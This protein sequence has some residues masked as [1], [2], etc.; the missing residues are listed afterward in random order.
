[1]SNSRTVSS[2][3]AAL[4]VAGLAGY[5]LW[6][7]LQPVDA[8][9]QPDLAERTRLRVEEGRSYGRASAPELAPLESSLVQADQQD[10][11]E[12]LRLNKAGLK[13][14]RASEYAASVEHFRAALR[15]EPGNEIIMLN[16]SRALSQWGQ[17]ELSEGRMQTALEHFEEAVEQHRDGGENGSLLAYALLRIGRRDQASAVLDATLK[18]FPDSVPGLRL[19]GEIAFL[20]GE[21]DRAVLAL[22]SAAKISPQDEAVARRLAFYRE[23]R[24]RFASYLRT[25][26]TRFEAMYPAEA[27]ELQPHLRELLLDLE[28]ASDSVNALLGLAPSDRIL[29]LLMSPDEY[30]LSAPNWSNG[31]YD[32]RIRIPIEDYT[33]QSESLR[34]TFRHEYT[35]AALHRIGPAVPTWLHEGLAQYVEG[36]SVDRSRAALSDQPGTIPTRAALG[37]DWTRWTDRNHVQGA[38]AYALSLT[39]WMVERYGADA[40]STLLRGMEFSDFGTAFQQAFSESYE[41]V[42]AAHRASFSA[43]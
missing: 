39:G 14:L 1:M 15:L 24:E 3:L 16:L 40:L 42:E 30:Q 26:S 4:V 6:A 32:G 18:E 37:G 8:S 11:P 5:L 10:V 19:A 23:E 13:S 33:R 31:L 25:Q 7:K 12:L 28:D 27:T 29:V 35:H 36:R 9:V 17:A 20:R 21:T 22:E 38:Y 2:L 41:Q 43:E 34:A